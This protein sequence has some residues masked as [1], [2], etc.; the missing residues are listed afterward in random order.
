MFREQ[1]GVYQEGI[2]EWRWSQVILGTDKKEVKAACEW[3]K[4]MGAQ[5]DGIKVI[6]ESQLW[7]NAGI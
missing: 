4:G 1:Q 7:A 5:F 2:K 6:K 3:L